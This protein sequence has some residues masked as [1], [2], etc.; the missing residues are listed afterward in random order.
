[1]EN[2]LKQRFSN[3]MDS[4]K[5]K[6]RAKESDS[7]SEEVSKIP[8]KRLTLEAHSPTAAFGRLDLNK[9]SLDLS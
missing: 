8:K 5:F 2:Y 3:P 1:M 7:D 4:P 9:S 6:A